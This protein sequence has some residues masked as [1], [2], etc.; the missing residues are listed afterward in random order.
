MHVMTVVI[1]RPVYLLDDKNLN[2]EVLS[3]AYKS[4]LVVYSSSTKMYRDLKEFYWWPK[5]KREIAEYVAKYG[6]CHQ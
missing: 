2:G 6:V 4:K 5:M 3:E 1:G